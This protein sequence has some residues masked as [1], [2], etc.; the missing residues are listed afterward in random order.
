[1]SFKDNL[2]KKITIDQA[3][4]KV[5]SSLKKT[6]DIS[7][8][9]KEAMKRLLE[10]SPYDTYR[11]ER[12]LDLY[13]KSEDQGLGKILVLDNGLAISHHGGRCRP[14]EKPHD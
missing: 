13:I 3:A 11:R 2:L 10:L 1:M 4:A 6:A 7:S 9:D 12:D 5:I 8:I 14:A